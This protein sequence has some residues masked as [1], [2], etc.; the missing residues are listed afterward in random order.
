MRTPR[1]QEYDDILRFVGAIN[2]AVADK[3]LS[4]PCPIA[5]VS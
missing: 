5:P 3:P 2:A 1:L 4:A